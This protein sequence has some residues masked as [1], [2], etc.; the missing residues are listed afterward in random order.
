[1]LDNTIVAGNTAGQSIPG[2]SD[3]AWRIAR[4]SF[5]NLISDAASAGGLVDGSDGN[6][7][8]DSGAGTLDFGLILEPLADNEG[9]NP[10]PPADRDS[11]AIDSGDDASASTLRWLRAAY[12]QRDLPR[13]VRRRYRLCGDPK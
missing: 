13:I 8:G 1:M 12:D 9:L 2:P 6:L 7:V 11:L 10:H 4:S 3:I 5:S